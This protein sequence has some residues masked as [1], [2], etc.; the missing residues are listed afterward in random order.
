[1]A[2][3]RSRAFLAGLTVFFVGYGLE[4]GKESPS[5]E[6]EELTAKLKELDDDK[7][8]EGKKGEAKIKWK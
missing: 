4:L 7:A 6:F 3:E 1:M 2:H 5:K 8:L